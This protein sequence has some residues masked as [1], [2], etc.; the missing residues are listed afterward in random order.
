MEVQNQQIQKYLKSLIARRYL[1]LIVS[2][3]IMSIVVFVSFALPKKYEASS[4]VF[5]ERN[6]IKEL[7][8]GI[9]ITPSMEDRIRVLRYAMLSRDLILKALKDLDVDAKLKN[10]QDVNALVTEFQQKTVVTVKGNDLFIV[11]LRDKNP[12]LAMNFVNTL[13]RKYVE[14]NVAA[15]REEAYGAGGF[16]D[17]QVKAFKERMD[18]AD[19]AVTRYRQSKGI[20]L[21]SDENQLIADIKQYN[22]ELE[23]I[24]IRKN[25]LTATKNSLKSQMNGEEPFTVAVLNR[26]KSGSSNNQITMR[27]ARINQLLVSYT[28]NYPEIVKL[29]AEIDALQK[30]SAGAAK[31]GEIT[32]SEMSTINPIHQDLKQKRFQAEAEIAALDAR[33]RETM[34]AVGA[35]ERELRNMPEGKKKLADLE[36]ERDAS[37]VIYEQL[38]MRQGQTEVSKQMEVQDKSTNFRVV[39]PAVLPVKPVS[40]DRVKIILLGIVAGI[41][42]AFGIILLVETF[43]SS[44]KEESD[45]KRLGVEVLAVIP[46]IFDDAE[47]VRISKKDRFV[48]LV[49]AGYFSLIC[50]V[51]AHEVLGYAYIDSAITRLGL[52]TVLQKVVGGS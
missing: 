5:I 35:K 2:L 23:K 28:E 9:A 17:E 36:K 11:S 34:G 49:S 18:K 45:L 14:E 41:G 1:F 22:V 19:E 7:V 10:N 15:K 26:N 33:Q 12:K 48:Y 40:P 43:N 29:R 42:G 20:Y 25:E 51:L 50:L 3:I 38:I 37:K 27:E 52:E 6:V 30:Q 16:L 44:I 46:K 31:A 47:A 4:T 32:E 13:V 21:S 8:K 39:D 24:K